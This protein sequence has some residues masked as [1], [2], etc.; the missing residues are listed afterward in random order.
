MNLRPAL[1]SLIAGAVM[2]LLFLIGTQSVSAGLWFGLLAALVVWLGFTMV[3]S[4]RR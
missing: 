4:R 2:F 3:T 1:W